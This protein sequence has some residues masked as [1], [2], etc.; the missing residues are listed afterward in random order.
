MVGMLSLDLLPSHNTASLFPCE[1]PSCRQKMQQLCLTRRPFIFSGTAASLDFFF[2]F[3]FCGFKSPL[4]GLV[5]IFEIKKKKK[6]T[7]HLGRLYLVFTMGL[8]HH[9]FFPVMWKQLYYSS[10]MPP[11]PTPCPLWLSFISHHTGSY[12]RSSLWF[13]QAVVFHPSSKM[14]RATPEVKLRECK[15]PASPCHC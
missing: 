4:P 14:K 15:E 10:W 13:W 5:N 6:S 2:S 3:F 7:L 9:V 1:V 8:Y 11:T 12:M